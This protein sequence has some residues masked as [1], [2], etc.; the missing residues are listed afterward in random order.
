MDMYSFFTNY[1]LRNNVKI[2]WFISEEVPFTTRAITILVSRGEKKAKTKYLYP[3][4]GIP[5]PIH[6]TD[7]LE[8]L[9]NELEGEESSNG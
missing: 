9:L 5:D 1:E 6:L 2:S 7:R 3:Y 8:V 4:E